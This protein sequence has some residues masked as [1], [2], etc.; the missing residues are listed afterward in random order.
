VISMRCR[1]GRG[2]RSRSNRRRPPWTV[3]DGY[4][5]SEGGGRSSTRSVRQPRSRCGRSLLRCREFVRTGVEEGELISS[6][7]PPDSRVMK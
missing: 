2:P 1:R 6:S 5:R 4:L 7:L 3:Y